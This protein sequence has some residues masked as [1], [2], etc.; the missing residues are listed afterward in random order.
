MVRFVWNTTRAHTDTWKIVNDFCYILY[1]YNMLACYPFIHPIILSSSLSS[2]HP[3][4]H[5]F[6]YPIILSPTASYFHP[7]HHHHH[8]PFNQLNSPT[9]PRLSHNLYRLFPLAEPRVNKGSVPEKDFF[10]FF[11]LLYNQPYV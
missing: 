6:T 9:C 2:F 4:S 5:T 7:P 3:P 8:H 10:L 11:I 1:N